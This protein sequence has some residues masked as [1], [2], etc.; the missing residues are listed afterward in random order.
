M[1]TRHTALCYALLGALMLATAPAAFAQAAATTNGQAGERPA[2]DP[3][4]V[5]S[6]DAIITAIYD[7]ISGPAGEKRDWDRFLSL[8]TPGAQLI[9][10]QFQNGAPAHTVLTPDQYVQNAGP[11]LEQ[12]GF[13]EKEVARKTERY[14][15]LV[16]AFS[17]YDSFR[18]A[19]DTE[20]FQRGIKSFQLIYEKD[21]WWIANIAWQPEWPGLPIP[22][23]YLSDM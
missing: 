11:Y 5:A 13:F 18:T 4:D 23:Q 3:A 6:V 21:R 22:E 15:N 1:K 8:H 10:I 7:V 2:A 12:N 20:P 16:H 17:T 19:E 9:P 14:G